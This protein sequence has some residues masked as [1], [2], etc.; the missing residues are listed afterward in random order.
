MMLFQNL[1]VLLCGVF[2]VERLDYVVGRLEGCCR[3]FRWFVVWAFLL[4]Y[5]AFG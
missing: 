5:R 4:S 1:M 2:V 3:A